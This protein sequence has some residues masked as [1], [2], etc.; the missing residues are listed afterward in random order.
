MGDDLVN[1]NAEGGWGSYTGE[2]LKIT[3]TL[4]QLVRALSYTCEHV[5]IT[6]QILQILDIVMSI[7]NTI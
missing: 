4:L 6:S 1:G 5:Q 7:F 3:K 2:R